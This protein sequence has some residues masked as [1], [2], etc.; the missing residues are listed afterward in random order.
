MK[1]WKELAVIFA[2]SAFII[3]TVGIFS[4]VLFAIFEYYAFLT[5]APLVFLAGF[6]FYQF[7]EICEDWFEKR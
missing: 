4:A 6:L 7:A 3:S 2:F 1:N 5:V